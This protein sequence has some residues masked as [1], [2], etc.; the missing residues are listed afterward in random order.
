MMQNFMYKLS[1]W[2]PQLLREIKGRWQLRNILL[3][4]AVSLLSQ[5]ILFIYCQTQLPAQYINSYSSY[6][7]THKY[8][9]G[10]TNDFNSP[11][12]LLDEYDRVIINWQL[13]SQDV[14]TLL[15]FTAIL[16]LL[17]GG[18]YLLISDLAT[19]ERRATLNFIRLSPQSPESI[20]YGKMLGVPILLYFGLSLAIP[21]HLSLGINAQIP[22]IQI[23]CFYGVLIVSSI[24]YYSGALLFGLVGTWL[25]GFQAWLGSG[26]ILGFLLLAKAALRDSRTGNYPFTIFH[27]FSPNYFL[28]DYS[29]EFEFAGIHWF[30]LPLGSS[31][32]IMVCFNIL[33]YLIG[34]YFFWQSLN[35]CYR[36]KNATMLS[37]KQSYLLTSCFVILTLGFANWQSQFLDKSYSYLG[38]KENLATLMFLDLGLFL[39]LIAALTPNRQTLQD[40]SRY[41]HMYMYQKLGKSKLISDLIWGEKSPGIL[42]IAINAIIAISCLIFFTLVVPGSTSDKLIVL[43]SV[44]FAGSLAIIYAALAQLLLLMKNEQRL[45]WANGMVGTVIILP[46][47]VL[48]M[49]FSNPGNQPFLWLLSVAAP[50]IIL[51]PSTGYI[52]TMTA[53]L[54]LLGHGG[55]LGLLMF[56]ITRQLKKSGESATKALLAGN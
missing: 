7:I 10:V 36:D 47:I 17:V 18:A 37:K 14:F 19:E 8:C 11:S 38:L 27:L 54:A 1:E 24:F 13:W 20:L 6:E 15:S 33:V 22:L 32:P 39:Y 44:V 16:T 51:Y 25:G 5:F 23:L 29:G 9:T 40:W 49:L 56:Q 41:R 45:F 12:C 34:T 43:L 28:N 30:A 42:A 35:R 50:I 55:I 46:P 4:V 52:P 53:F 26:L 2:N 21:F 31:L 3:A 48:A